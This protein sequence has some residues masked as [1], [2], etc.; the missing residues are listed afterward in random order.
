MND[1]HCCGCGKLL[2]PRQIV[3]RR[4]YFS[5]LFL[6]SV[7]LCCFRS[8][9]RRQRISGG[10]RRCGDIMSIA[11]QGEGERETPR[12]RGRKKEEARRREAS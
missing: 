3:F 9:G 10:G 8:C 11:G 1:G 4:D 5:S 6:P 2:T 7:C 12:K